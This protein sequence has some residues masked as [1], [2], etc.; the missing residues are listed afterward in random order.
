MGGLFLSYSY[1]FS[2]CFLHVLVPFFFLYCQ[3]L[4]F[5]DF[6]WQYYLTLFHI[7]VFVLSVGFILSSVFIVVNVIFHAQVQGSLGHF[8]QDLFSNNKFPHHLLVWERIYFFFSKGRLLWMEY[9]SVAGFGSFFFFGTLNISSNSLLVC[10]ISAEKS[11]ISLMET[12]L[13]VTRHFSF[14]VFII[15]SSV[16]DLRQFDY[17]MLQRKKF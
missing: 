2:G 7:C 6:L 17:N 1:L 8:L 10:K 13:Q 5:A 4:W 15:F 11:S 9:P 16:I 12:L 3:S 14:A